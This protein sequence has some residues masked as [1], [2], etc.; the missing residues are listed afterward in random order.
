MRV[1]TDGPPASAGKHEIALVTKETAMITATHALADF[2]AA[3]DVEFELLP[4]SRT[5]TASDE[6]VALGIDPHEVAKTIILTTS[7]GYLRAVIPATARLDLHKVRDLL[8]LHETPFLTSE[9]E[10]ASAYPTF[11]L[12]AVPPVGGPSGDRVVVDR[13][14]ADRDSL[15]IEAG[16]HIESVLVGTVDLLVLAQAEIGDLCRG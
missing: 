1:R 9:E 4:H 11:E 12:G 16:S 7:R 15:V 5:E 10:L 8:A 13:K 3:E 2:L 14:L 6:A